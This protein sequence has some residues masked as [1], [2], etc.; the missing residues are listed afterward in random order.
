[1]RHVHPLGFEDL[2]VRMLLS[3]KAHHAV[4]HTA[5]AAVTVPLVLN[6]TLTVDQKAASASEDDLGDLTTSIPVA[7]ELA[8]LGEVRGFWNHSDDSFG[9]YLGPDTIQLR[10]SQGTFVIVFNDANPGKAHRTATGAVFN[11]IPQRVHGGT[12]AYARA[13]ESGTIALSTNAARTVVESITLNAPS[14]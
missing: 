6:G 8:G 5:P 7:G 3:T 13:S 14:T 4:A 2:E 9:D 12:G 1:M 10:D 11:P